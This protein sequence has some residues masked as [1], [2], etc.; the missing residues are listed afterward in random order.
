MGHSNG[1]A[2][3]ILAADPSVYD[4]NYSGNFTT[5]V[6]ISPCDANG[7]EHAL[8]MEHNK[9]IFL[10]TGS[11]DCVCPPE[12][13]SLPFYKQSNSPCKYFANINRGSHCRFSNPNIVD[14]ILCWDLQ[15]I[16]GCGF[17]EGIS[18]AE[19]M[20]FTLHVSLVG[21]LSEEWQKCS[22]DS[23]WSAATW[24]FRWC[25]CVS[26]HL[27]HSTVTRTLINILLI[28]CEDPFHFSRC[29]Q[30]F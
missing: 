8:K 17:D 6:P 7:M 20:S 19:Q 1:G 5:I 10:V 28:T 26:L 4:N 29:T 18:R 25:S 21:I 16:L 27:W 22:P 2:A 30:S 24:C 12:D 9:T 11:I 14:E 13:T 3:S 15:A 23:Q